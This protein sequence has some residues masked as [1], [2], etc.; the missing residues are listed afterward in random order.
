M[1]DIRI[2]T[3]VVI[4]DKYLPYKSMRGHKG[5]VVWISSAGDVFQ[6]QTD[7]PSK[8]TK[9]DYCFAIRRELEVIGQPLEV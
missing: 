6:I 1:D 2:G 4:S 3:K 5:T 9:R 8:R 7:T